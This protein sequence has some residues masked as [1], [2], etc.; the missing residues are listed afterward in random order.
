[1][2]PRKTEEGE[3]CGSISPRLLRRKLAAP[4]INKKGVV[5]RKILKLD[6]R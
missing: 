3:F 5:A 4:G 1:M 2:E 6:T